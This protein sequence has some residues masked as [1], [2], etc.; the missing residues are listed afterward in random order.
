MPWIPRTPL[1]QH[2]L[3]VTR[4]GALPSEE[5]IQQ[6][7]PARRRQPPREGGSTPGWMGTRERW[8]RRERARGWRKGC[9]ASQP[10]PREVCCTAR[11][12][13]S[14]RAAEAHPTP[15]SPS[16]SP[17]C[18]GQRGQALQWG[19][20]AQLAHLHRGSSHHEQAACQARFLE[21]KTNLSQATKKKDH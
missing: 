17:P 7:W 2:L 4:S 12:M 15:P 8:G 21:K 11:H 9:L 3:P 14:P 13:S 20:G 5:L 18:S 1:N 16:P 10:F 6:G 19:Q